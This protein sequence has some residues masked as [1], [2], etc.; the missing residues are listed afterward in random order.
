[1][2]GMAKAAPDKIKFWAFLAGIMLVVSFTIVIVD[3]SIKTAI[4]EES[5][6]LRRVILGER[7]RQDS[8]NVADHLEPDLNSTGPGN[9]LVPA[10]PRMGKASPNG[11]HKATT[12]SRRTVRPVPPGNPEIPPGDN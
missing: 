7:E 4:L 1:M 5:A 3:I 12:N 9:L 6:A 2:E 11:S 10:N 8:G